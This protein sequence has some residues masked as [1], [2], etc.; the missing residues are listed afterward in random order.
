[1]LR[2]FTI[3]LNKTDTYHFDVI[4]KKY[5]FI[6]ELVSGDFES[7]CDFHLLRSI[8]EIVDNQ[9]MWCNLKSIQIVLSFTLPV[10]F[11]SIFLLFVIKHFDIMWNAVLHCYGSGSNGILILVLVSNL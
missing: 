7:G 5:H 11:C 3:L 4:P 10:K 8:R 2:L 1:M 9:V 6:V